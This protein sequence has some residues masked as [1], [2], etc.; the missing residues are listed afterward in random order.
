MIK[1]RQSRRLN[2][3][4]TT[5]AT[6]T[7]ATTTISTT[8]NAAATKTTKVWTTLHHPSKF[9]PNEKPDLF[10]DIDPDYNLIN[11]LS[12]NSPLLLPNKLTDYINISNSNSSLFSLLHLNARSLGNKMIDLATLIPL[13]AT[14][15]NIIAISETWLTT[16]TAQYINLKGYRHVF[17]NRS[18]KQGG[19]WVFL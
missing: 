8:A 17:K 14:N 12:I 9:T 18:H 5:T 3:K 13:S 15:F 1:N 2:V 4:R 11:N 6:T 7:E 19:M 10:K 16:E